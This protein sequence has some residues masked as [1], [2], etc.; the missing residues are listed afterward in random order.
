[1]KLLLL[2]AL[3][4]LTGCAEMG[5]AMQ[6]AGRSIQDSSKTTQCTT[7]RVGPTYYSTCR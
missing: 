3:L 4:A 7:N 1:M 6:T 5:V 2:I